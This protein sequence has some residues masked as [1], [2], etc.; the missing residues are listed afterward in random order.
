MHLYVQ[1]DHYQDGCY[2]S[3]GKII[4]NQNM[5]VYSDKIK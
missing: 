5:L 2:Q 4:K 1:I 3:K